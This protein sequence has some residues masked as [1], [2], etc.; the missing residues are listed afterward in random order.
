MA[1]FPTLTPSAAPITPG[2]W[3]VATISSLSGA[4][5]RTR[6]GSAQIGRRL[7]LTFP[8]VTEA[9]FLA[10]LNHYRGQRSGFDSFGFDPTT[11]A[12]DLTPAGYAWLYA[13]RPQVVDEHADVF[14]V[15]CEF[16]A[17]PRG[18]VVAT[19]KAWRTLA[20]TLTPGA[21]DG[22]AVYGTPAAWVTGSTTLEIGPRFGGVGSNGVPWVTSHT[23]FAR[24]I[25]TPAEL[26]TSLWLDFA[27]TFTITLSDGSIEQVIDKSGNG[28]NATQSNTGKRPTTGFVNAKKCMVT[29]SSQYLELASRLTTVRAYLSVVQFNTIAADQW[30]VGDSTSYDFHAPGIGESN[31]NTGG[32]I[33]VN[34]ASA[35]TDGSGWINGTSVAPSSMVRS[36]GVS[37]YVFNTT[38]AV[39]VSQ[40]TADRSN[41]YRSAGIAGNTCEIIALSSTLSDTDRQKLEG[42]L[43]HK[44]GFASSLPNDHPYK[45]APPAP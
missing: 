1:T 36:T 30:I 19:G 21:R 4:E 27:D 43:A 5:S 16:K 38:A 10:I 37:L 11:L 23:V 33:G 20:T 24:T 17:E 42:Y 8:N 26:T 44:W 28:R 15:V 31:L 14:T 41:Q 35:V 13:S 22:G 9:N 6:Q 18:L 34:A 25:W 3:P 2:A 12:S 45:S 40:F 7:Q 29:T 39:S 32:L